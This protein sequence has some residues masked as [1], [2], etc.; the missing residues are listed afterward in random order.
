MKYCTIFIR[1]L[2]RRIF[3]V[4]CISTHFFRTNEDLC[5]WIIIDFQSF[6]I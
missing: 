2:K 3:I 6:V 4:I 5:V 1:L